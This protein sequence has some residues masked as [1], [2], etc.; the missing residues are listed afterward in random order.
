MAGLGGPAE[1]RHHST[2]WVQGPSCAWGPP[3]CTP[4]SAAKERLGQ[5]PGRPDPGGQTLP[6]RRL[7]WLSIPMVHF[8]SHPDQ[9]PTV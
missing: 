8:Q 5:G 4:S 9:P 6:P 3:R 2:M 7:T 1:N